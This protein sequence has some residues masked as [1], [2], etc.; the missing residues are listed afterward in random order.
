M[1]E[2]ETQVSV[3]SLEGYFIYLSLVFEPLSVWKESLVKKNQG[4]L[5]DCED[6][7]MDFCMIFL[8][9]LF[10]HYFVY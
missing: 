10:L 5:L 1:K 3:L 7:L 8:L 9:D 6:C 2:T 4:I